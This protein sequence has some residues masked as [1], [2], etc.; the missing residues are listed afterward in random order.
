[1]AH[2]KLEGHHYDYVSCQPPGRKWEFHSVWGGSK[3]PN[4]DS[5]RFKNSSSYVHLAQLEVRVEQGRKEKQN[6][7][8]L[9]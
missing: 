8:F 9:L 6:I 4:K 1:M 7:D 5:P 2:F 3:S